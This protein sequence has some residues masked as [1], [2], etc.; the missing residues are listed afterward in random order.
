VWKSSVFKVTCLNSCLSALISYRSPLH[1]TSF[2]EI[3]F[4]HALS[5]DRSN[6]NT[7]NNH[8]DLY[9]TR[10]SVALPRGKGFREDMR[11]GTI[12]HHFDGSQRAVLPDQ[13]QREAVL[14][15]L[16]VCRSA[17]RLPKTAQRWHHRCTYPFTPVFRTTDIVAMLLMTRPK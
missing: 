4:S 10:E 12:N 15:R 14:I 3:A 17:L 8:N 7:L 6:P 16:S 5:N 13:R 9:T 2:A 1:S 11:V